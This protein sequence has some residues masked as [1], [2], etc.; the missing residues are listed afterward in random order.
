MDEEIICVSVCAQART[1]CACAVRGVG[2][3]K[4]I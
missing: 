3:A 2:K 4:F 1:V